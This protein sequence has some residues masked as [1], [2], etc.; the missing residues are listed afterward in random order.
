MKAAVSPASISSTAIRWV[1]EWMI[2]VQVSEVSF[3]MSSKWSEIQWCQTHHRELATYESLLKRENDV[4]FKNYIGSPHDNA[5]L[6]WLHSHK[7]SWVSR[8]SK[9]KGRAQSRVCPRGI[10]NTCEQWLLRVLTVK[11]KAEDRAG[12]T[13]PV[14]SS[15]LIWFRCSFRPSDFHA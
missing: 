11:T 7:L 5:I 3:Q 1:N 2:R 13:D 8:K 12:G 6:T 9:C 4:F 15:N 10:W 14:D